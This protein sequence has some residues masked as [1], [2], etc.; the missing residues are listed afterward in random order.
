MD[1]I[2]G[3]ATTL[4]SNNT[5]IPGPLMVVVTPDHARLLARDGYD[6]AA[7]CKHIHTFAYHDV[8]VSRN[9]GLMP[10]R[11]KSFEN[12][13]PM[14]VTRSVEDVEVVVA[15]GHGGHSA[16]I[17]PWA[18]HSESIV[19]AVRLPDGNCAKCIN[20]FKR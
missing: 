17:L 2:C 3:S 16:I 11:P 7:I 14:P 12:R 8:P 10:V 19:E 1:T 9:R 6:K 20:D 15:G 5:Y 4:G 18:L 13:H